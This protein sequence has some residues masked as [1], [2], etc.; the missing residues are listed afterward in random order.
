MSAP[1]S[2]AAP[3]LR[4]T[5]LGAGDAFCSGGHSNAAYLFEAKTATFLK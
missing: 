2:P 3:T 4:I 1:A 5:I